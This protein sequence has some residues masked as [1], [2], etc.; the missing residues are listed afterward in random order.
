M[1]SR[2]PFAVLPVLLWL[3]LSSAACFKFD[4]KEGPGL[5]LAYLGGTGTYGPAAEY[6]REILVNNGAYA[7][8]FTDFP[9]LVRLDSTRIRYAAAGAGGSALRFTDASGATLDHEIER[10]NTSGESI[11]WVRLPQITASATTRLYMFYGGSSGSSGS[12]TA[13]GVWSDFAGVWHLN[14]SP[15]GA[16]SEIKDSTA[17]GQNGTAAGAMSASNAITGM[18]AGGVSFDGTD[19]R[20]EIPHAAALSFSAGEDMTL[21]AFVNEAALPAGVTGLVTKSR[22]TGNW[23]GLWI[24]AP[25][26]YWQAGANGGSYTS[27]PTAALTGWAHLA[28]TQEAGATQRRMYVN[29]SQVASIMSLAVMDGTG[30]LW[31]GGAKNQTEYFSGALDEVRIARRARSD[32]YMAAQY[33]SLTDAYLSFGAEEGF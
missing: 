32:L 14:E 20:V 24:T 29:G 33:A 2:R 17:A 16:G 27:N 11:V 13:T 18:L 25:I 15:S 26:N 10:W 6:R 3:A 7:E 9:I 28:I 1:R 22:D 23:Y 5:L 4:R 12:G 19:D 30:D 21:S 8:T 31:F